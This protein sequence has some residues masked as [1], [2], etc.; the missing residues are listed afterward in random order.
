MNVTITDT[1]VCDTARLN[2]FINSGNYDYNSEVGET[3]KSLFEKVMSDIDHWL[4]DVF[5]SIW[6]AKNTLF[7][8]DSNMRYVWLAIGIVLIL[9]LLFFM[10]KR[11]MLFF[12]K[13]EKANEE[14]KVV[15]D[16][17]Y[18]IDF[19]N[20]I[21]R[22]IGLGN[23][24]EAIRLRYLQCLKMLS[25]HEAIDWRIF[26]TPAQY[27]REFKDDNFSDLTRQYVLVRY[28]GYDAS[29]AI[30][31]GICEKYKS[32]ENRLSDNKESAP[33]EEGGDNEA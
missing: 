2:S 17:I 15:E 25:D 4:D 33:S 12:K 3:D 13:K 14:Y 6:D 23:Y 11:K 22:A 19:E 26:K 1:L 20:D 5:G 32:I 10:Y 27:T 7:S 8:S 30:Y 24:R 28:G 9:A 29:K 16:T 21:A 31:D 18:G